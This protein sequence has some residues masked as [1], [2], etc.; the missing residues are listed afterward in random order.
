MRQFIVTLKRSKKPIDNRYFPTWG[1]AE[2]YRKDLEYA[3]GR[4]LVVREIIKGFFV[5]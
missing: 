2:K 1:E 3:N 5:E 4:V